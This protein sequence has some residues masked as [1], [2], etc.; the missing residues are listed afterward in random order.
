MPNFMCLDGVE[1][2]ENTLPVP[3][4]NKLGFY[5]R[6]PLDILIP[7]CMNR[8]NLDTKIW[9]T[10]D[11]DHGAV[12]AGRCQRLPHGSYAVVPKV[13]QPNQSDG[14]PL[15]ISI[16]LGYCNE[17]RLIEKG[18]IVAHLFLIAQQEWTMQINI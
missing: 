5:I 4:E 7:K 13:I 2:D 9:C 6:T 12:L 8:F 18:S 16:Q 3:M 1:F 15:K 17:E 10:L 14:F 11:A